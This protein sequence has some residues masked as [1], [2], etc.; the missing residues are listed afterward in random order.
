MGKLRPVVFILAVCGASLFIISYLNLRILTEKYFVEQ[1]SAQQEQAEEFSYNAVTDVVDD[2]QQ[3]YFDIITRNDVL[4][5][6]ESNEDIKND[7]KQLSEL[8]DEVKSK[9]DPKNP[10]LLR[11]ND[12][13]AKFAENKGENTYEMNQFA[14]EKYNAVDG[15]LNDVYQSVISILT[16][17]DANALRESESKWLKQLDKYN[18]YFEEKDYGTIKYLVKSEYECNMRSFRTLLLMLYLNN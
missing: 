7:E 10:F 16:D 8:F 12:I 9:I 14:Q 2:F 15:L 1:K 6:S 11:Y 18:T 5:L 17:D 4:L 13:S 3:R